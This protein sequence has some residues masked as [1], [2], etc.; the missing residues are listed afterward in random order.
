M[1]AFRCVRTSLLL[2][3]LEFSL[4]KAHLAVRTSAM[5]VAVSLM[6]VKASDRLL[7]VT[8]PA[9]V[10][11]TSSAVLC[12]VFA[13]DMLVADRAVVVRLIVVE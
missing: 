6:L 13:L 10:G 4:G 3:L 8:E 11:P 5:C 12:S 9:G 7:A 2:V 1:T